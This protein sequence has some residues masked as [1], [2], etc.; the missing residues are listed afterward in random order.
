MSPMLLSGEDIVCLALRRWESPWKNNQQVMSLMA[1]SNRVLYVGPPR[2]FRESLRAGRTG[3]EDRQTARRID[4]GL[5]VYKEPWFLSRFHH[6]RRGSYVLN[7]ITQMARMAHV[8]RVCR[9]LGFQSPILWVYDPMLAFAVGTFQEKLVVYHVIDNY[10]EYFHSDAPR[11]RSL[12]IRNHRAVLDRA[13]VV[14]AVSEALHRRCLAFNSNAHFVPN[15]VNYPL[16]KETMRSG[17]LPDDVVRIP[18]PIVGYI[19]VIQPRIDFPLLEQIAATRPDWSL[20]LVGPTEYLDHREGF[21]ALARRQNVYY[22]GPKPIEQVPLYMKACDVGVLPYK[23]D[24]FSPYSDS[25]KLYE[26]LACGRPI[27]SSDMPS[28][29]R[30]TPLVRIAES[31]WEFIDGI[32]MSLAE[33]GALKGERMA[34]AEQHSWDRRV[35]M[36][37]EIVART[38]D[39]S[40][41]WS[42]PKLA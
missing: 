39:P 27:V 33:D 37:S 24:G 23:R 9:R 31:L 8:R 13:H 15:G 20:M 22:L 38:L 6:A 7:R 4:K 5:F 26:Y 32:E 2:S 35:E 30:F 12:M 3:L 25:L 41:G 28:S 21:D 36:M 16:F 34:L 29:R 17:R 40:S 19:G 1:R 10:D 11:L 18:R 14:F 42:P